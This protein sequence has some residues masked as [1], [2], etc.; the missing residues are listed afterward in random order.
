MAKKTLWYSRVLGLL[1]MFF[2]V[3]TGEAKKQSHNRVFLNH[4]TDACDETFAKNFSDLN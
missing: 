4:Q 1:E 2:D 3:V